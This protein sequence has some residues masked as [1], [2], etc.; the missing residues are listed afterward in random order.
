MA[1]RSWL[2]SLMETD[3][4]SQRPVEH[5]VVRRPWARDRG[6]RGY[7]NACAARPAESPSS[8]RLA[9]ASSR[10]TAQTT[11]STFTRHR[12]ALV[13][14]DHDVREQVEQIDGYH[15][16]LCRRRAL[17]VVLFACAEQCGFVALQPPGDSPAIHFLQ[18]SPQVLMPSIVSSLQPSLATHSANCPVGSLPPDDSVEVDRNDTK[19]LRVA[20][21]PSLSS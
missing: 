14:T 21:G 5:D 20:R 16:P 7:C 8:A 17:D 12:V 4:S 6:G 2:T 15:R 19:A 13:I 1:C 3:Y 18:Y 11:S 9:K 10:S